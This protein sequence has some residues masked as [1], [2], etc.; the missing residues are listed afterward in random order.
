MKFDLD[1]D[2]HTCFVPCQSYIYIPY[3]Y[4]NFSGF[5]FTDC[6]KSGPEG[7]TQ[8]NC[9]NAYFNTRINVTVLDSH[10][11]PP[12]PGAQVWTVPE[13]GKYSYETLLSSFVNL[14][15]FVY[16]CDVTFQGCGVRSDGRRECA[17]SGGGVWRFCERL[18]HAGEG[19]TSL[20]RRRSERRKRLLGGSFS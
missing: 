14:S 10:S 19:R 1:F 5:K 16:V 3:V 18:L 6:G 2:P 17:R 9:N 7:P 13:T 20:L 15:S 8:S 12:L 11:D 4:I